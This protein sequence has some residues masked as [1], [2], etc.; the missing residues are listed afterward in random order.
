MEGTCMGY[1]DMV[2]AS[3]A[4]IM[5]HAG[6][7]LMHGNDRVRTV[8]LPCVAKTVLDEAGAVVCS[9]CSSFATTPMEAG[10]VLLFE[11]DI[12]CPATL[13]TDDQIHERNACLR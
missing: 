4:A 12:V 9:G 5:V 13:K 11:V 3:S 10:D 6:P 2:A 8:R 1:G 7:T